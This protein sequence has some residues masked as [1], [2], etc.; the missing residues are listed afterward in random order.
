VSVRIRPACPPQR[1]LANGHE[2]IS[3]IIYRDIYTWSSNQMFMIKSKGGSGTMQNC[4][5]KNFIGHSNAYS[6]D[7]NAYWSSMTAVDGSGVSYQNL[8]FDNWKGTCSNRGQRGPIQVICPTGV[9]CSDITI[10][11]SPC[12]PRQE[13]H[14]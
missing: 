10:S 5:F 13:A 7:L 6:M 3:N 12:G 1:L 9:P 8:T 2:A 4:Q 11:I 14:S